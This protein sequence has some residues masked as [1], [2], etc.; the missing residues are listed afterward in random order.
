MYVPQ[1]R[2]TG[3]G[4]SLNA[5]VYIRGAAADY[6][7]WAEAGCTGWAWKDVLPVFKRAES[8]MR[9][10]GDMHGTDGPLR[11]SD[12]KFRHPLSL[13]FLKARAGS[14]PAVQRR[15]QQRPPGRRRLLPDHDDR[16]HA[17]QHGGD[18]PGR[19]A[20][21]PE[22]HAGQRCA[23]AARD[24]RRR[25]GHRCR[26]PPERRHDEARAGAN[27]EVVLSAGA[28]ATPKLLQV[29]GIGPGELLQ[30]HRRAGAAR[31]AGCRRELPGPPRDHRPRPLP[32]AD[33]PARAGQGP[34]GAEA[35]PAVGAVQDRA[36]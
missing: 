8:N 25:P 28:L 30:Q 12:T 23:R 3:G 27:R 5:M 22:A 14:G 33:Q 35:R 16:R 10:S 9:F 13:A 17:R 11:V 34:D 19:G 2:M 15:L 26:V 4:S 29:S 21:R 32:R 20:G 6:D 24:D 36:A 1:G 18:L 7:A 31:A